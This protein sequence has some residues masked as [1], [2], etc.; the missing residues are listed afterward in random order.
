MTSSV[1]AQSE[2]WRL[3]NPSCV[4]GFSFGQFAV[5]DVDRDGFD[6]LAAPVGTCSGCQCQQEIWTWSGRTGVRLPGSL[7]LPIS[8]VRALGD[9]DR[10]GVLDYVGFAPPSAPSR[11]EAYDGRGGRFLWGFAGGG[12]TIGDLDVN[13]DGLP[14]AVYSSEPANQGGGVVQE[15]DGRAGRFGPRFD[16]LAG[17]YFLKHSLA[18]VGDLDFDG[19]DDFGV[20]IQLTF[21]GS[22]GVA[23][24]S[25]R[26]GLPIRLGLGDG[27]TGLAHRQ[28]SGAGDVDRDGVP[29]FA[30]AG[31]GGAFVFSGRT[32]SIIHR[33]GPY[34]GSN[35]GWSLVGG[36]DLDQDGCSDVIVGQTH[37]LASSNTRLLAFSGRDGTLLWTIDSIG[38]PQIG[39]TGLGWPGSFRT[40]PPQ[41]GNPFPLVVACEPSLRVGSTCCDIVGTMRML[42]SSPPGVDAYGRACSIAP[43]DLPRGGVRSLGARTRLTVV[44]GPAGGFALLLLGTSRT[45]YGGLPLPLPLDPFGLPACQLLTS[46]DVN[47]SI[48]LGTLGVD[49]G[50]AALDLPLALSA[51]GAGTRT[52]YA[53]WL[54][55]SPTGVPTGVSQALSLTVR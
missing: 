26:L 52:V 55:V 42:R 46:I 11:T 9:V 6:D 19:A 38:P 20:G 43:A 24:F 35:F 30:G 39:D 22:E 27:A 50:Y 53:Q 13:G 17:V 37:D 49:R 21:L 16:G 28:V 2:L 1:H 51:P 10:D 4:W 54:V 3:T 12:A 14:D 18:A 48:H 23:I 34:P 15:V 47:L 45:Q 8:S 32:G 41:A 7:S 29:D 31:A 33:I 36:E 25:G 44:D 5:G 40:F